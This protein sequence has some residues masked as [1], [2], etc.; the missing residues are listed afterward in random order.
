MKFKYFVVLLCVWVAAL[1]ATQSEPKSGIYLEYLP[2]DKAEKVLQDAKVILLPLGTNM[3]EHGLHLP[4]NND[5][6]FAEY[7]TKRVLDELSIPAMPVMTYGYFPSFVNF[8]G[9]IHVSHDTSRD[10]IMDVCRSITK[11]GPKKV[12]ILNT[13]YTTNR[14]L[15]A[16][17]I[18]LAREGITME[19]LNLANITE[20]IVKDIKEQPFGT[21]ADEIETSEMMYMYPGLVQLEL[22]KPEVSFQGKGPLTRD[23]NDTNGRYT[24]TGALGDPTLATFEKGRYIT[25]AT[26]KVIIAEIK[27]FE[28]DS[29]VSPPP[30]EEYLEK[31]V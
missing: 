5:R 27:A 4:L 9:S 29:Y 7:Y 30:R 31:M 22:A 12:Y 3:K 18:L 13:G 19:Y 17:R 8:P 11:F 14:P 6:L 28:D 26:L 16:A 20:E 25:E 23:P 1:S 15:E 2:W 24:A 10:L 21:H